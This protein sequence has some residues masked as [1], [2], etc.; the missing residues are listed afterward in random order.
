MTSGMR[1][2]A[3]TDG[4]LRQLN[5][6]S[7]SETVAARNSILLR[8]RLRTTLHT[9]SPSTA[10]IPARDIALRRYRF[11]ISSFVLILMK[12]TKSSPGSGAKSKPSQAA[13]MICC[14]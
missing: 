6:L 11:S 3:L 12:E 10:R 9:P 5:K 13:V 2:A 8:V 1:D 14:F 4:S 7:E